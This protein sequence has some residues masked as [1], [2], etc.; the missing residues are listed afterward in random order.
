MT[1]L[2]LP[3]NPLP[4]P[5][6]GLLRA[7]SLA[8]LAHALLVGALSLG[9]NWRLR[10]P[11]TVLAAELWSAVPKVAAP[12][13]VQMPPP[14]SPPTP[15]PPTPAVATPATK[16]PAP[17]SEPVTTKRDAQIATEQRKLAQQREQQQAKEAAEKIAALA[18]EQAAKLQRAELA[19]AEQA[20]AVHLKEDRRQKELVAQARAQALAKAE[21]ERLAQQREA[22]LARIRSQAGAEGGATASGAASRD[23]APSA[24]YAGRI[25]ARIK[26]NIV[27]TSEVS[28]NPVTE[29]EVRCA[30]DGSIIG[31]RIVK[32]SGDRGWD[33]TVL[34]AID[35]TEVLPRDETGRVPSPITLVMARRE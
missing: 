26:A 9:L 27:L 16:A 11:D 13:A 34:R 15:P 22:N 14:V 8:L 35:R 3:S 29:V 17:R 12:A 7:A 32:S 24:A 2:A 6:S 23:A 31:R 1:A 5:A 19:K 4:P 18:A 21:D 33:D 20:K 10:P 25:K 30:L 28:G